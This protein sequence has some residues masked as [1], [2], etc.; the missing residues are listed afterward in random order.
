MITAGDE[1]PIHQAALP[2]A[3]PTQSDRNFYDRSYL[4]AHDR[5]GEIFVVFG[6]GHYPN[7]GVKDAFVLV[8]RKVGDSDTNTAVHLCDAIDGDRLNPRV[9][10]FAIEVVEPLKTLRL[11]LE[12]T[13]GIELDMTWNGLFDVVQEQRHLMRQ[14]TR[15]TL[16]AQ[17]FAQVGS[18]SGRLVVD[19]EEFIVDPAT[20]IGT[21]DRSWGIRPVGE[22]ENPGRP[23]DPPFQG[24]WWF[25]LPMAFD[26]FGLVMIIQE[27]PD[28]YR[29]LNDCTRVWRDGR[30]EQL[31]WPRV[32]IHYRSGTRLPVGATIEATAADGSPVVIE[33]DAQ[34]A[35]PLHI[36]GGY[37]GDPDWGH[38]QWKGENF[39]E[40]VTY[41]LT[42]PAVN[43]R[44]AFGV[45]DQ[46]GHA[47]CREADGT[48]HEGWGMFEHG[49]FGLHRPSGFNDWG[50]VA[51]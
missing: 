31:G 26:D 2:I 34:C 41:D 44:A 43:G 45:I 4:C 23:A 36:G 12:E 17:R 33:A 9:G 39:V 1:Y 3:W 37:G 14:G 25:Y 8:H 22:P 15:V 35:T 47:V 27:D 51:P 18:W 21:R 5:S 32:K 40:R 6:L 20:W 50:D 11:T 24:M 19:G 49:S 28:G 29:T 46:V 42:D 7:L 10:P 30:V 16:D 13:E 48:E 38:G